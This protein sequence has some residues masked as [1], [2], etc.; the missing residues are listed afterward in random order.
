MINNTIKQYQTFEELSDTATA[1][2]TSLFYSFKMIC[3]YQREWRHLGCY[4]KEKGIETYTSD[5]G[6]KYLKEVIGEEEMNNLSRS[7]RMRIRAVS[8]LSDFLITGN[9]RKR[10]LNTSVEELDGQIGQTIAQYIIDIAQINNYAKSTVQSH[11]LYLSRFLKYLNEHNI[12]SFDRFC[13]ELM[14]DFTGNLKEYSAI[15]RHFIILKTKQFL[16]YLYEQGT[17]SIDYSG[18]IPKDKY[19]VHPKLPSYFSSDEI[20]LLLNSIDRSNA[21]GKRNYAM[22][23]LVVKLGLRCSDVINMKFSNI[24]WEQDKIVLSQQKTK[25]IVELPLLQDIGNAIIDY[26][27]YSRPQSDLPYLFLCLTP[28]YNNLSENVLNRSMQK[29]LKFSGIKYDERR[30]GPHALRHSL[31]TNLLKQDISLPVISG[32]LGHVN[33]ESTINYLRIDINSLRKCALEISL[34][35]TSR[36]QE[37]KEVLK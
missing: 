15:T 5:V 2:L 11:K 10:K 21:S 35:E 9:I 14:V 17:L 6:N 30:H 19:V 22:I 18:I 32:I 7:K 36:I 20:T 23:L 4:M 8:L 29:Y 16:K 26:L 3:L 31:A 25:V 24:Q 28:P 37:N 33:T 1:Y 13:P 12:T 27:K 34:M